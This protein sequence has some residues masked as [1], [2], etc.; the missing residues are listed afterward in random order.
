VIPNLSN[1]SK[2]CDYVIAIFGLHIKN[3]LHELVLG[4]VTTGLVNRLYV[5][6]LTSHGKFY[7]WQHE[8]LSFG[9]AITYDLLSV[10]IVVL[11]VIGTDRIYSWIRTF[12]I[13][14]YVTFQSDNSKSKVYVIVPRLPIIIIQEI[15]GFVLPGPVFSY[16][17]LQC[18]TPGT[19][20]C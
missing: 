17:P 3:F 6:Y 2:M 5:N 15:I 12:E 10:L 18:F 11:P 14:R 9:K 13:T 19:A 1:F 16:E 8:T 4:V 20:T 7:S